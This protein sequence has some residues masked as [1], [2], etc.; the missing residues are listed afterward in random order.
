MT[1]TAATV[2]TLRVD[3]GGRSYDIHIGPGLIA[4]ADQ[5]LSDC[6]GV[7][8]AFI[9]TD[10]NVAGHYLAPI[11]AA[12]DR[13]G[14]RHHAI[15]LPAGEATKSFETWRDVSE[16]LLALG[17]E[18][19]STIIALGGG[20][21]GDLAGFIAATLLRG[22]DFVQIPTT[23][24]AQVDSSV[25]G[26]TAINSAH[27][28]NLIGAFFQPKRVLID[29][30]VL[31]SLPRRELLAG[32]AET[33]K[34]GLIGDAAFFDWLERNGGDVIAGDQ[35]ARRYAITTSCAAKAATV[36]ADEREH[37]QRALLNFG[38][39]FAHA[40]EAEAG[41]DSGLLHGEAV[42]VG[43]MM[44]LALS[45]DAGLCNGQDV[46]RVRRHF[47]AVGLPVTLADLPVA[48]DWDPQRLYGHMQNDK[49]VAAGKINFIAATAIG[50]AV[51]SN[52]F[53]SE[54]VLQVLSEH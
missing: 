5:W 6:L 53:Q 10:D 33:V 48:A 32:Y 3:L 40:L 49:K 14:Q 36:R 17:A 54:Q 26:K 34:Y 25:G 50:A 35:G 51:I 28:K 30:A 11:E 21:I 47:A 1:L 42:A 52:Q 20:V 43:M 45:R 31:D 4:N 39:T 24:L 9:I 27:G 2:D 38:H 8:A 46:A 16:Q 18:R 12:L 19:G 23:L 7:G 15:V 44:A 37:G 29:I 41:Y 22:V 13:L